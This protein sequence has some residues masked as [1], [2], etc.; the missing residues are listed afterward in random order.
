VSAPAVASIVCSVLLQNLG[1]AT[2]RTRL[3]N[4]LERS[5]LDLFELLTGCREFGFSPSLLGIRA[6]WIGAHLSISS[7]KSHDVLLRQNTSLL[8]GQWTGDQFPLL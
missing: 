5:T 1:A 7:G 4:R 6:V 3:P 2:V 8:T